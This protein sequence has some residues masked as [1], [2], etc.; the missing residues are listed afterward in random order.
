[1]I[2]AGKKKE[3]TNE[4]TKLDFSR[5]NSTTSN[6]AAKDS[7]DSAVKKFLA[8]KQGIAQ[9][10]PFA[11]PDSVLFSAAEDEYDSIND[12]GGG[13]DNDDEIFGT[14]N[15]QPTVVFGT[16][17]A[18]DNWANHTKIPHE[19]VRNVTNAIVISPTG[20]L[21]ISLNTY[22]MLVKCGAVHSKQDKE[23]AEIIDTAS[24]VISSVHTLTSE[25]GRFASAN[26]TLVTI[27][28]LLVDMQTKQ[29]QTDIIVECFAHLVRTGVTPI[30][31]HPS[32]KNYPKHID[33]PRLH[34]VLD[35]CDGY[36]A[37]EAAMIEEFCRI[38][39]ALSK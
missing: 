17:E 31:E 25:I 7:G 23:K 5:H 13:N 4:F 14:E 3:P 9:G 24:A 11:R 29:S 19:A 15:S 28:E 20:S 38:N 21:I 26:N 12:I 2:G 10:A 6:L 36:E 1:M 30:S 37:K 32:V 16:R 8:L 22:D 34:S 33:W 35:K 18:F 39:R 27:R